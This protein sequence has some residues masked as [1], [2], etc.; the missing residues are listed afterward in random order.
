MVI[1]PKLVGK[2]ILYL[3][4][5]ICFIRIGIKYLSCKTKVLK[6][7]QFWS[8]NVVSYNYLGNAPDDRQAFSGID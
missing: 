6:C 1:G 5:Q 3:N 2:F 8:I 7:Y 4:F